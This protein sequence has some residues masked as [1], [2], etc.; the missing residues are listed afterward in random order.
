MLR[1]LRSVSSHEFSKEALIIE[2]LLSTGCRV[3]ELVSLNFRDYERR[4]RLNHQL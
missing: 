1:K 4:E 3:S 2:L